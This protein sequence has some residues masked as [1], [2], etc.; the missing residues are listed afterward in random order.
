MMTFSIMREC[1]YSECHYAE[2]RELALCAECRYAEC[3]G[4]KPRACALKPFLAVIYSFTKNGV[5]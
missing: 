4:A 5:F 3:L 2:C 1:C